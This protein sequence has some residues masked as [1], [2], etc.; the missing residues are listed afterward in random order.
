MGGSTL[1]SDMDHD[2]SNIQQGCWQ[3]IEAFV[4][5]LFCKREEGE[6]ERGSR[7]EERRRRRKEALEVIK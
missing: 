7:W 5:S 1:L 4:I 3:K 2:P 6:P